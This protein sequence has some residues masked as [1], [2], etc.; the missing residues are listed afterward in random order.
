MWY[1][2]VPEFIPAR[3][4]LGCSLSNTLAEHADNNYWLSSHFK[5]LVEFISNLFIGHEM[6]ST[7]VVYFSCYLSLDHQFHYHHSH[8]I[9]LTLNVSPLMLLNLNSFHVYLVAIPFSYNM[10]QF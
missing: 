9:N 2:R 1:C 6:W 4:F 7:V 3:V 10:V 8:F 5:E